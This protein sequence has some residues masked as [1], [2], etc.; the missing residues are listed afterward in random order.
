[1]L[2]HLSESE[3]NGLSA[4][5]GSGENKMGYCPMCD[6]DRRKRHLSVNREKGVAHCFKC[7]A[8]FV[9]DKKESTMDSRP[10][11][12]GSNL[13]SQ[14]VCTEKPAPRTEV[15]MFATSQKSPVPY[16]P[17]D[18][19]PLSADQQA[20][21]TLFQEEPSGSIVEKAVMDYLD[22]IGISRQTAV[23][24]GLGYG[25]RTFENQGSLPCVAYVYYVQGRPVNVKYRSVRKKLFVQERCTDAKDQRTSVPYNI[26]CIDP[27]RTGGATIDQ[28]IITEGEKDVMTLMEAGY[29]HVISLSTG[30]QSNIEHELEAFLPW[31]EKV[32]RFVICPDSDHP[33]RE[34][35]F[36]LRNFLPPQVTYTAELPKGIKDI[37]D[38]AKTSGLDSVRSVVDN[39]KPYASPDIEAVPDDIHTML[40]Y[41][42]GNYDKG[43]DLQ[44]GK[45]IDTMLRFTGQGGLITFTGLSNSG[46][47]SFINCMIARLIMK[48]GKTVCL[49]SF[50][51]GDKKVYTAKLLR[52]CMGGDLRYYTEAQ[53][54]PYLKYLDEHLVY[55]N[56]TT[57]VPTMSNII[58]QVE[59]VMPKMNIDHLIVDPYSYLTWDTRITETE[60]IRSMLATTRSWS[61][62]YHVW[63]TIVVHPRKQNPNDDGRGNIK[64]RHLDMSDIWGSA[65]WA[66]MSDLIFGL[67]RVVEDQQ[68]KSATY[69]IDYAELYTIKSR[70]QDICRLG[71]TYF[72]HQ[73]CGRF[74]ER[75]S[76]EIARAE[77]LLNEF[78]HED[79]DP[80]LPLPKAA[81]LQQ[82][83]RFDEEPKKGESA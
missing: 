30:A 37:S 75:L 60:Y 25:S 10:T 38:V 78:P 40:E 49:C 36:N 83:I 27:D 41:I 45:N 59:S 32:E 8:R 44:W 33:G 54:K 56:C 17:E 5:K 48:R 21:Y 16:I 13:L 55:I 4:L 70:E 1:M 43:Y 28:L 74:D 9:I 73:D 11:Y 23:R 77:C 52:I 80:W 69:T 7:G 65:H 57:I 26:Q 71:T 42:K 20:H 51:H 3:I 35:A 68:D 18:Y 61:L 31:M 76:A 12:F 2:N 46:K 72:H 58:N 24:L 39:A 19:K 63:T 64:N 50:E 79:N 82:D 6:G 29:D 81:D 22:A 47:T 15:A 62:R 53:L 66:N 34:L 14:V 67:N